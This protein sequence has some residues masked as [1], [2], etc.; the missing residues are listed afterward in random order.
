MMI[1][2]VEVLL[3]NGIIRWTSGLE[4]DAD[5]AARAYSPLGSDLTSLDYLG[6]AGTAGRW[7]GLVC[8]SQGVPYVQQPG[9]PAPG[10]YVSPTA[11]CDGAFGERDPRRYVDA[12]KIPY[13]AVP[14]ELRPLGCKLG[15]VALVTYG[16]QSSAAIVSD[17]GPKGKI[18]EGSIALHQAL[19]ADPF[20]RKPKHKLTGIDSGVSVM[21]FA[22]S[23]KGWPRTW[24]A[25]ASQVAQIA[26]LAV[27]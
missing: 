1:G 25:V 8:N 15:D 2:D 5:G 4:V 16:G 13:L 9:H 11:L 24:D 21:L 7:W 26:P 17:I 6:N 10:Y 14:P 27:S 20:R 18:G 12:S 3:H 22:G 19:G 23:T